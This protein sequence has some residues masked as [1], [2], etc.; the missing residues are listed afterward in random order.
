[1]TQALETLDQS[2]AISLVLNK[3]ESRFTE[4]YDGYYGDD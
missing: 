3:S 4:Y 2:K 1:L